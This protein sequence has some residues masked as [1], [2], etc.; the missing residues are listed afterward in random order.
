MQQY[1]CLLRGI[2]VGGRNKMKMEALR[3]SL[4]RA[5]L[6]EV[7]TYIQ[8]GNI[9][10]K[11]ES[12][13]K[14]EIDNTIHCTILNDFGYDVPVLIMTSQEF[15]AIFNNNPFSSHKPDIKDLH[16]TLLK[17]LPDENLCNDLANYHYKEDQYQI[18]DTSVYLWIKG[19]YGRTKL[20]NTFLEKKLKIQATTRNWKTMGKIINLFC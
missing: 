8:S 10:F 6:L 4:E 15:E 14:L 7:M 3:Q 2:N 16:V 18:V 12:T 13:D 9:I 20:S 5:G 19:G 1:V 11:S 17:D